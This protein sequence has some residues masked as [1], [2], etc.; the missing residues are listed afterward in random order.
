MTNTTTKII[1]NWGTNTSLDFDPATDVLDF[2]WFAATHFEI[3]EVDGSVVISIPSNNQTYTLDG[4]GLSDLSMT[5]I[6]G[7]DASALDAWQSALESAGDTDGGDD[8]G[9]GGDTDSG[10]ETGSD[11]DTGW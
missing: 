1:W 4:V 5:N 7:R 9:T 3:I 2:G 11:G 10:G 6:T 8:S